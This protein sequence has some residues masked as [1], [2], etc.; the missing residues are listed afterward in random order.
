[1]LFLLVQLLVYLLLVLVMVLLLVLMVFVL[2]VLVL[3]FLKRMTPP[4]PSVTEVRLI[5]SAM[6]T[7]TSHSGC[8][9]S[10]RRP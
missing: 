2:M 6:H 8:S 4:V 5:P 9:A 7:A 10:S 3:V 1:M